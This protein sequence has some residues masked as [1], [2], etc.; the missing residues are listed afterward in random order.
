VHLRNICFLPYHSYLK[1]IFAH[2]LSDNHIHLQY[3][4]RRVDR[5]MLLIAALV[6]AAV[7]VDG[8]SVSCTCAIKL[9]TDDYFDEDKGPILHL[10]SNATHED[11]AFDAE[12]CDEN[13]RFDSEDILDEPLSTPLPNDNVPKGQRFCEQIRDNPGVDGVNLPILPPGEF[14]GAFNRMPECTFDDWVSTGA[15]K[16][17][18]DALLQR[19]HLYIKIL[20][21]ALYSLCSFCILGAR[22]MIGCPLG[23]ETPW[24]RFAVT[25]M[26]HGTLNVAKEA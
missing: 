22:S 16:G 2:K 4:H 1:C 5:E 24:R 12:I 8:Q 6:L 26:E 7:S 15:G 20:P 13:C 18:G 9:A 11:C 21:I 17:P 10:V 14:V 25:L 19:C 3:R 23:Q